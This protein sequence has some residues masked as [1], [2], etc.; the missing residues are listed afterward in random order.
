MKIFKR[1]ALLVLFSFAGA[2]SLYLYSSASLNGS[3]VKWES[4]SKPPDRA[5]HVV[6]LGFV[7]TES[8]DIYRYTN[9]HGCIDDC[10]V[11]TDNLPS[12]SESLPLENCVDLPSLVNFADSKAVCQ[13]W[14]PG[15]SLTI[16][17]IDAK[18]YVYSWEHRLGEYDWAAH[19]LS[20]LVGGIA[21]LLV[22]IPILLFVLY[23][24]WL[25]RLQKRTQQRDVSG[26]A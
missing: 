4:L 10:W 8:G 15:I 7:K 24:D 26:K 13:H 20:P 19:N 21:G 3:L 23:F 18:G 14:G 12:H 9:E 17:A 2:I 6:A 22:A 16:N 11:K 5:I 1:I 25:G